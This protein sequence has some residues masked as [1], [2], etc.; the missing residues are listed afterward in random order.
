[1]WQGVEKDGLLWQAFGDADSLLL[2]V[3]RLQFPTLAHPVPIRLPMLEARDYQIEAVWPR[4]IDSGDTRSENGDWLSRHGLTL[5]PQK[6]ET[7]RIV[8]L[9]AI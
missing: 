9:T 7:V 2:F 1:M 4:P 5:P 6:A 8:R 3:T